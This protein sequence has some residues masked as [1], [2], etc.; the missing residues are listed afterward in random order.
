[1]EDRDAPQ[2]GLSTVIVLPT[3]ET[4]FPVLYHSLPLVAGSGYNI[5]LGYPFERTPTWGFLSSLMQLVA[6]MEDSRLYIPDYL[7]FV[8]HPYTKNIYFNGRTETTRILFHTL[9]ELLAEDRTRCFISLD[10]IEG[11]TRLFTLAEERLS[12]TEEP[13]GS[14]EIR[15]HLVTIHD[16]LI[17]RTC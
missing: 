10:E 5:S 7:G 11:L 2:A 1:M 3:P 13:A 15:Q 14:A 17:R 8:L 6:S 12:R 9:E 4:L 16:E